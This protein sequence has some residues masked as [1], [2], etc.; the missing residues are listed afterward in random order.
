MSWIVEVRGFGSQVPGGKLP[1]SGAMNYNRLTDG[2]GV[3]PVFRLRGVSVRGLERVVP[4]ASVPGASCSRSAI[5]V[6]TIGPVW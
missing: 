6:C 5:M 2:H 4:S 3:A 1:G